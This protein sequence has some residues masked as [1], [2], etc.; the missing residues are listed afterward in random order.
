MNIQGV[1]PSEVIAPGSIEEARFALE[2]LGRE[3]RKTVFVGG[4]T[5]LALGAAPSQL[6][7]VV[8]TTGLARIIEYAPSD[9]VVT[10]EAGITLGALQ[11][12]LAADR[13]RLSLDAPWPTRATLGG[14]IATN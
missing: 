4:G 14:I 9:Q 7:A 12:R 3:R 1:E 8:R 5:K 13:Q 10:V 11:D 2:R 6:D